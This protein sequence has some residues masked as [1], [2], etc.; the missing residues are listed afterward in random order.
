MAG[1][2]AHL[3]VDVGDHAKRVRRH[4]RVH[5]GLDEAAV[6]FLG[7][8]ELTIDPLGVG[9]VTRYHRQANRCAVQ[10]APE[11]HGHLGGK[12]A[13][14]LSHPADA[15]LPLP[16]VASLLEERARAARL[17]VVGVVQQ[18]GASAEDV[19]RL[20]AVDTPCALVPGQDV[21][22]QVFGDDRILSR[23]LEHRVQE[24][25][26][27]PKVHVAQQDLTHG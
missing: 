15:P 14:V 20:V 4:Q 3:A 26:L 22:V 25:G 1:H 21:A 2:L 27:P 6:V 24:R 10:I 5:V 16:G 18:K 17:H 19:V 13:A 9:Q 7:L 8:A 23:A 12:A 11:R